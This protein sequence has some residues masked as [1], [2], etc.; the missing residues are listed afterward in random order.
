MEKGGSWFGDCACV[1]RGQSSESRYQVLGG[2]FQ[3][4][5]DE[6]SGSIVDFCSLFVHFCRSRDHVSFILVRTSGVHQPLAGLLTPTC[7]ADSQC[8]SSV[9]PDTSVCS[10]PPP[11]LDSHIAFANKL[12]RLALGPLHENLPC[13]PSTGLPL[14]LHRKR[15]WVSLT[16]L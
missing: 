2:Y 8:V 14:P 4:D 16:L 12:R 11:L 15:S 13:K 5:S 9:Y 6:S 10:F 7:F 3:G 1:A